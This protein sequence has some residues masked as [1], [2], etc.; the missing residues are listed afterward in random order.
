MFL[1]SAGLRFSAI[2]ALVF[3]LGLVSLVFLP[4]IIGIIGIL[5]GGFAV[6]G[7]FI[8]TLFMY[9]GPQGAPPSNPEP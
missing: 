8:R 4:P 1:G 5:V 6:W 2:G 3:V 7:G 9:Y